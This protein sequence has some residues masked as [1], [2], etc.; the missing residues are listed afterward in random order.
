MVIICCFVVSFSDKDFSGVW[1]GK[2]PFLS[3][4]VWSRV[5]DRLDGVDLQEKIIGG[6]AVH[7]CSIAVNIQSA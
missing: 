2:A 1:L 4:I 3:A 5:C 7:T 6:P